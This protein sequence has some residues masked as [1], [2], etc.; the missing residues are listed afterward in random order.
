MT[1]KK[2]ARTKD[3]GAIAA[4]APPRAARIRDCASEG[5]KRYLVSAAAS[6][7]VALIVQA[8]SLIWW[9]SSINQRVTFLENN[10]TAVQRSISEIS[11]S[12]PL[13]P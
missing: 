11:K 13:R 9:A 1:M 10:M 12:I 6:I 5:I 3:C 4:P 7:T 2:T 8:G